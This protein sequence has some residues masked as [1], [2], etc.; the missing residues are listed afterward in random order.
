M[1]K[2]L[3]KL[4][5]VLLVGGVVATNAST[6]ASLIRGKEEAIQP[7]VSATNTSQNVSQN[8][9]TQTP[10]MTH[11]QTENVSTPSPTGTPTHYS[12][13]HRGDDGGIEGIEREL[14]GD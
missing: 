10:A 5:A 9:G 7:H 1:E 3:P 4:F 2:M 8:K 11:T 13:T 14:F 12:V 6:F